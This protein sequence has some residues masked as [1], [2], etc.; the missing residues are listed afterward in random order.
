MRLAGDMGKFSTLAL[1]VETRVM[2]TSSMTVAKLREP[3][4]T[5]SR[6]GLRTS[7]SSVRRKSTH[8]FGK[9]GPCEIW[10]LSEAQ[11][12]LD[13]TSI[14]GERSLVSRSP[15]TFLT[16]LRDSQQWIRSYGGTGAC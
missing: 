4:S 3:H 5:R 9:K 15:M 16:K 8:S 14:N 10:A 11:T 6:I 2:Q 1:S 7:F 13:I 12:A